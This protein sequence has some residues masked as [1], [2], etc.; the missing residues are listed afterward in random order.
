MVGAGGK[1]L[2]LLFKKAGP[3]TLPALPINLVSPWQLLRL[4]SVDRNQNASKFLKGR[5][6]AGERENFL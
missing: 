2:H 4:S 3:L 5:G 6:G 1:A